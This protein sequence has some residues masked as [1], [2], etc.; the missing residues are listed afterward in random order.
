[1]VAA[2]AAPICL[3]LLCYPATYLVV[4]PFIAAMIIFRHRGNIQRLLAGTE[5]RWGTNF[6]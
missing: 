5:P 1:M 6:Q 3:S 2:L 4:G